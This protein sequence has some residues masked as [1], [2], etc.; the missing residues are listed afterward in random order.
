M[1]WGLL[2]I[3]IVGGLLAFSYRRLL[4]VRRLAI[5]AAPYLARS[6]GAARSPPDRSSQTLEDTRQTIAELNE[7][8]IE[9]GF[10]LGEPGFV[11]RA[12]AKAALFVGALLALIQ[13][14]RLL[15]GAHEQAWS[16]PLLSLV[17][18]CAGAMGCAFIGRT[19]ETE[20]R[21]LRD[22]WRTLIRRSTQDVPT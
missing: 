2:T 8:T 17:V 10:R 6:L 5:W 13:G 4:E 18:G 16:G 9:L 7:A 20:A 21:R 15:S 19:A 14:A 1:W 22:D 12:C 11:P 3:G